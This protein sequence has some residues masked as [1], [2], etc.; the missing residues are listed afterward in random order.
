M[1]TVVERLNS[2]RQ[3]MKERDLAAYIVCTDDFHGSEYVGAYFKAREFMSGFTGSAGTL[4]VLQD[5]AGLWTDG[6]YFLQAADQLQGSTIELMK[7]GEPEVPSIGEYLA[8]K[9]PGGSRIGFDGRTVTDAFIGRITEKLKDRDMAYVCGEDLVDF[10]WTDRPPLSKEPVWE[11]SVDY[12]GVSRR[13]KLKNLRKVMKEAGCDV[14]VLTALDDI[15]W[16]L[17]LRGNDIPYNPVFLSYMIIR[18]NAAVLYVEESILNE[19]I[20]NGLRQDGVDLKPYNDIYGDLKSISGQARVM[21]DKATANF[22]IVHSF[23]KAGNVTA[24]NSPVVQPKAVKTPEEMENMRRAHVKD[25]VAVTRFIYWLKKNVG[26]I[27]ITE[28]DAAAKL[29]EFRRMGE[30]YLGQ[31]FDPIMGYGPHG[32]IVHY[33]P[34]PATDAELKPESFLL[35]DTGGH[36]YEGTTDITRT[37]A[38]GTL[39]EEEKKMFTLVL[40]GHLNLGAAKFMYGVRGENLDY[41]ARQPL[42]EN[43]L[44]FNHGTGHGVGYILNVHERPNGIRWRVAPG[45]TQ[46]AVFEEGMITSDEP[47]LYLTGKFGIRHENLILCRKLMKN[48]YGQFMGFEYLTMVPFDLEA[49]DTAYMTAEEVERLNA[50]HAQVYAAIS[51]Y[52]EG[53]ELEWLRDATRA[54]SK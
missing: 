3:L 44:D 48:E 41:I 1:S 26:K 49:V 54:V 46:T 47:G 29:E 31:S 34:T 35:S 28:L 38:L 36:Y 10:V 15:A 18:E 22:L 19:Q 9:L 40:K 52:F 39:T 50:Y 11:L 25:G 51:P 17:N 21:V 33:E 23:Q 13:E 43:G 12:T 45:G 6:R 53:E 5:Q 14:Q 24:A 7:I 42:W 4:V 30:G 8:E 27:R 37:I 20:K 2:L 32:A 16:L